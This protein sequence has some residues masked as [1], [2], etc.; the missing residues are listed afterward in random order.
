MPS[1]SDGTI[2]RLNRSFKYTGVTMHMALFDL[3][4][5]SATITATVVGS[6]INSAAHGLVNGVRVRLTTTGNLPSPLISGVDYFVVGV[7]AGTYQLALARG[8]SAVSLI[9]TGTGTITASE[10]VP[11]V[12]D[13]L[14][15]WARL[16]VDYR[17]SARQ[18]VSFSAVSPTIVGAGWGYP[19]VVCR[20]SPTSASVNYR[21]MGI[22][23]DG[24]ATRG[25]T[26]GYID[27]FTD[28]QFSITIG[29]GSNADFVYAPV[30]TTGI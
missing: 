4:L 16:E 27:F 19:P 21:L 11:N 8:G 7:T 17:G 3:T 13:S 9:T 29:N 24:N 10:Q 18:V 28:Y 23:M 25:N 5:Y 15:V 6:L 12:S 30:F 20:F 2:N 22:I 14:P 26:T 1:T